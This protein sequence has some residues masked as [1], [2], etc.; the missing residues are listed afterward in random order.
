MRKSVLLTLLFFI[1]F[2]NNV[3]AED[4]HSL[5]DGICARYA[6]QEF[7]KIAPSPGVNWLNYNY[8][9]LIQAEAAGWVVKTTVRDVMVGAIAEWQGLERDG[10]H[11]AI[12][13]KV[14]SD[15][16]IVEEQNIGSIT[17]SLKYTF[18]GIHYN[19]QVTSGWGTVTIR[20]IK[21]E[22]MLRMDTKKF[23]GYIWPVR[24]SEYE[25]EPAKYQISFVEQMN[26]KE[27]LY[28]GFKEYWAPA[29]AL[30]EFDKIVP[31]PGV[32]WRGNVRDW[33]KNSAAAG[34]ITKNDP[35]DA[36]I[37]AL[38]IRY[39]FAKDWAKVGIVR[40][41]KNN[42]LSIDTRKANLYPVS[43]ELRIDDLRIDKEGYTFLGY[44]WPERL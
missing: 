29:Y 5:P 25:K 20:A 13:R 6:A 17:G 28:K 16:I 7:A 31:E 9:W 36:R 4:W 12:V 26:S 15:R 22:D 10:G 23:M 14:L 42:I 1:C 11:V 40:G 37:G 38:V 3:F 27:P 44:I 19:S 43:E 39:N 32:N 30:K 21:Y 33:V 2:S 24:K 41:M 34:W 18:Q 35:S 8:D